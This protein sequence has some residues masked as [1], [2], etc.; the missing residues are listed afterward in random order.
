V[1]PEKKIMAFTEYDQYDGLGLGELV[2]KG[3]VKPEELLDEAISRT[4]KLNPKLNAIVFKHYEEAR[5]QIA[6]GLPDGAFKGVPFLLKDLHLLL[7]GTET[8]FGSSAFHGNIADHNSTLTDRYLASGVVVFGKTNS[9]EFGLSPTTEPRAYG[10]THNPWDLTRSP[11]G[12]SGGA[13][14]AVAA[15]ILPLANASDGG[16]SIRIPAS[17]CG[18]FGMKPTRARTPMGPDRGEGWGGMSIAHVV[19]R[20]VRD[21]AAML[22]ATHGAADGDA[23]A[24]PHVARPFLDEVTTTPNTLRVAY[25]TKR[26]DGTACNK[27]V[28]A[29][30]EATAKLLESLGHVVEDAAPVFDPQELGQHQATIIGANVALTLRQRAAVLGRELTANDV[31]SFTMLIN[32]A[33]KLRSGTDYAASSLYMHQMGRHMARFHQ[34]YDVYLSATLATPPIPLG[35]LDTSAGDIAAYLR[36]SA[37]YVPNIGVYNMTGQPSMSVPLAWSKDGLPLGMM[38]TGRFGDEATLFRLAGQLEQ[39]QPW[40]DKRPAL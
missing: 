21:S 40:A 14:A 31:E 38:F 11:G 33:A 8:S 10:A 39:A 12:S 30:I 13:A 4:E 28:V 18:L 24:A 23:Y 16:G 19:S 9:P 1:I 15:G 20:S 22:D 32:E 3:K 17:A 6:R 2:T 26:P 27:E 7:N 35:T 25:S 34:R 37:E 36:A 29:A 5:A